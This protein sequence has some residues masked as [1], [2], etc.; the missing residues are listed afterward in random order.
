MF[1]EIRQHSLIFTLTAV[2]FSFLFLNHAM[3]FMSPQDT[4]KM[5][6]VTYSSGLGTNMKIIR[7]RIIL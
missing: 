4:I 1:S 2:Q 6:E 5:Y 7:I 3:A